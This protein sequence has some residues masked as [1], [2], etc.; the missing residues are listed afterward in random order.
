MDQDAAYAAGKCFVCTHPIAALFCV[1]WRHGR[2]IDSATSKS[3][4]RLRNRNIPTK[5]YPDPISNNWDRLFWR[6]SPQQEEKQESRAIAKMTAQCA[7]YGCRENFGSP[8]LLFPKLS[9][10]FCCDRSYELKCVQNLKF[11]ALP[12]PEII[13]VLKNIGKCL[14]TPTLPY[15]QNF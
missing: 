4:I 13:W 7:L 8:W 11:V 1:K 12:V 2:H 6:R 10:G 5:F 14:D 9:M 15:L 3:K